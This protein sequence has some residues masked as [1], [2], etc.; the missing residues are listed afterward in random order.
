M[1]ESQL[2]WWERN[3]AQFRD[4]LRQAIIGESHE[5]EFGSD[6]LEPRL[7]WLVGK[8]KAYLAVSDETDPTRWMIVAKRSTMVR[9]FSSE[10]HRPERIQ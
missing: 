9:P 4:W 5:H 8:A 1:V 6:L 7:N 3:E 2:E 10:D